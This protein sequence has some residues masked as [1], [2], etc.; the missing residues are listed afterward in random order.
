LFSIGSKINKKKGNQPFKKAQILY[1]W[2]RSLCEGPDARNTVSV[3]FLAIHS[4]RGGLVG[5]QGDTCWIAID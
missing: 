2:L 5:G 4:G 3:L 1:F